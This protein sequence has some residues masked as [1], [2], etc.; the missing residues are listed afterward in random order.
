M[1]NDPPT[2]TSIVT[3]GT[4][5]IGLACAEHLLASGHRV[6]VFGTQM[7][8][9]EKARADLSHKFG[10]EKVIA[11]AVDLRE[12]D[13]L[14]AFFDH[15]ERTWSSPDV[16]VCNAG[17]SPKHEGKR[18]KFDAIPLA[19]WN[20]VL[21]V[22][23]TGTLLCCQRVAPLM[24]RKTFGRIILI[25]S[26]A[27]RAVPRVAG[28]SYVASKAALAGM[29]KSLVNEYASCAVTINLIAP[30]NIATEMMAQPDSALYQAAIARI[31]A[32]RIGRP[33]D[34]AAMVA[35]LSSDQAEFI[36]GAIIDI[37]GGE[38]LPL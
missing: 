30:G 2:K 1:N 9:V 4:A 11:E 17:L 36:N 3:G 16:L 25:G 26:I 19:E 34:I 29:T 22:N 5:G 37:N 7:A 38:F 21:A 10:T 13:A 35:F 14:T 33:E 27:S 18:L 15:V 6:A 8:R 24:A 28:A 12:R 31:P 32:G 23:L 20:D